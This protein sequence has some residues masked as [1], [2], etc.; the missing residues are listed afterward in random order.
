MNP[1]PLQEDLNQNQSTKNR[2]IFQDPTIQEAMKTDAFARFVVKHWR[3]LLGVLLAV[4]LAMI[5]ANIFTTTAKNK[6]ATA[7]SQLLEVQKTYR[8]LVDKQ[9]A[10]SEK[11]STQGAYEATANES[12][13]SVATLEKE[14]KEARERLS[15]MIDSLES[16][17][18][19]PVLANLYKGLVAARFDDTAGMTTALDAINGWNSIEKDSP[20]RYVAELAS[21]GVARAAL[22]NTQLNTRGKEA[23]RALATDGAWVAVDALTTLSYVTTVEADQVALKGVFEGVKSRYPARAGE[24]SEIASRMKW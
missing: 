1:A 10:L 4:S 22:Q 12:A 9:E 20:E 14:I 15:L 16:P 2:D 6:R 23:L 3:S 8:A 11:R 18:P 17:D 13:E 7:T 5:A 19:F 24:L 21:L